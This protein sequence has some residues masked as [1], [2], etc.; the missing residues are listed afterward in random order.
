ME[1]EGS[2]NGINYDRLR[3]LAEKVS[4]NLDADI[5]AHDGDLDSPVDHVL[6]DMVRTRGRRTNVLLVIHT[7]GGS[8]DVAYRVA[9]CLQRQYEHFLMYVNSCA[10]SAGTLLAVGTHELIIPD[11]GQLGPLDIQL[12]SRRIG[13]NEFGPDAVDCSEQSSG[14]SVRSVGA[15]LLDH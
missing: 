3:E 12:R 8:A 1:N 10:K 5:I 6:I 7:H 13:R 4:T 14:E 11:D 2:P 9:R 15:F